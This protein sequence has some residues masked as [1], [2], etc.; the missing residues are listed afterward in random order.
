M[1]LLRLELKAFRQFVGQA[2]KF[3]PYVTVLVGRN[4]TGKT[5]LLRQFFPHYLYE[6]VVNSADRPSL[7]DARPPIEFAAVWQIEPGDEERFPLREAFGDARVRTIEIQFQNGSEPALNWRFRADGQRVDAYKDLSVQGR[8]IRRPPFVLRRLLPMPHYLRIDRPIQSLFEARLFESTW[9]K[10][11]PV[12]SSH[13][14]SLLRLA[15]LASATRAVVGIEKP[16]EATPHDKSTLTVED[17]E[18]RLAGLSDRL[19]AALRAWWTDPPSPKVTVKLTG[20][21]DTKAYQNRVNSYGLTCQIQ[22]ASG[23]PCHGEGLVWFLTFLVNIELLSQYP[24]PMYLL[25]DEPA[26]PLHPSAQRM[27]AKL[28]N[29]LSARHQVI[30]STHSPFLIDWNFPHR[31]RLLQRDPVSRRTTIENQPYRAAAN[32]WDPLRESIGVTVG[33]VAV[34][35][36]TNLFVEGPTDQILIANASAALEHCGRSHL[37]LERL[38]VIAYQKPQ[39]LKYLLDAAAA[40]GFRS[41]VLLDHDSQGSAYRKICQSCRVPT[42]STNDFVESLGD[43]NAI[44]DVIGIECYVN[45]V[46]GFYSSYSWYRRISV[47]QVSETKGTRS[48]GAHLSRLFQETFAK[49]FQK[50]AVA[51]HIAESF[52]SAPDSVPNNLARLVTAVAEHYQ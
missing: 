50:M 31:V 28:L 36:P 14:G 49:D 24:D 34:L 42:I 37:D 13:E 16:W 10:P 46:N 17:V 44:E 9:T 3:D 18:R 15:G 51:I 11:R 48:L 6:E 12:A 5:A 45:H 20:N 52:A 27:V 23:L 21:A 33:D 38:S 7:P 4:D 8:P 30:Y 40:N 2:L 41:L 29:S 43:A 25:L 1:R 22:D 32:V 39:V 26:T 19:T 35:A 47:E